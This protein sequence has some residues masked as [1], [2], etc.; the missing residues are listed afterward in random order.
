MN[1]PTVR[2]PVVQLRRDA[3]LS[4]AAVPQIARRAVD[5]MQQ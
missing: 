4:G 2:E 5:A 3:P 1:E